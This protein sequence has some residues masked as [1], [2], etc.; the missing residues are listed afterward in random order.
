MGRPKKAVQ[1]IEEKP[2]R[3]R[4]S[5]NALLP[6]PPEVFVAMELD[7]DSA[8]NMDLKVSTSPLENPNVSVFQLANI[9]PK[10]MA[11]YVLQEVVQLTLTAEIKPLEQ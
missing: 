11:R 6:F 4:K 3:G 7:T 8:E 9:A 1:T 2:K 5:K 10:R